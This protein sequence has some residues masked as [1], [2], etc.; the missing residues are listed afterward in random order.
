MTLYFIGVLCSLL[1]SLWVFSLD[2][3][4]GVRYD[5]IRILMVLLH[6]LLSWVSLALSLFYIYMFVSDALKHQPKQTIF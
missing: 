4:C 6:S 1:A 2:V 5:G 3:A